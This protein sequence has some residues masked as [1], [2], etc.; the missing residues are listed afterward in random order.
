M[1]VLFLVNN[2]SLRGGTER[3]CISVCNELASQGYEIHIF[4]IGGNLKQ[5]A[6]PLHENIK[7]SGVDVNERGLKLRLLMP[8]IFLSIRNYIHQNGISH[9]INVEIMSCLFTFP[10]FFGRRNVKYIVWEH[11]N[12]TVD[13][14]LKQR[15]FFRKLVAKKADAVVTLTHRDKVMWEENLNPKA[16]IYTIYNPSPFS[17]ADTEYQST[18]RNVI[19]VG[20]FT[21]QKGYD[22]LIE[23]WKILQ[24][25]HGENI[26]G[27]NLS[28]IGDGED[29]PKIEKQILDLK[30][31][32]TVNLVPNTDTI[33]QYYEN[34]AFLC[35]S[36][37]FEGLP[38][39][40]IE[41]QSNSL[42]IVA[43]DCLTGPA[44]IVFEGSGYLCPPLDTEKLADTLFEMIQNTEERKEMSRNAGNLAKRFSPREVYTAW[45]LLL[46]EL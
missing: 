19:S 22:L 27:W 17:V 45:D 14:G 10:F 35:M 46:Q 18:S 41:A 39:V 8:K 4:S 43:F 33:N 16:R 42:P 37:R 3:A 12:Y 5:P 30:V 44:D 25:K 2:I 13:L 38:M 26:M 7:L 1:R 36:S 24:M 40:L 21:Y 34:A 9:L 6:F 28:I 15:R 23:S 29:K 31:D 32:D 11:F 20:R